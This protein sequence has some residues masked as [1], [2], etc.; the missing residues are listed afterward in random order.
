MIAIPIGGWRRWRFV[1]VLWWRL[2]HLG[3]LA[4]VA[5]QAL[6]GRACFLTLWQDALSGKGGGR[7]F[8]MGLVDGVIFWP[9]PM[10]FFA[11]LYVLVFLYVVLL[12][13][14]VPAR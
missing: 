5:L 9:L 4:V 2:L 12:F 14:L 1:R 11:A 13:W 6:L 8:I 7:P 3:A 10:T